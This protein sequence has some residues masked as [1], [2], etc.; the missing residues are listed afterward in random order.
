[1]KIIE[2]HPP[3]VLYIFMDFLCMS[4]CL[5]LTYIIYYNPNLWQL[6]LSKKPFG[7]LLYFPFWKDYVLVF[8]VQILTSLFAFSSWGLY[9]TSREWSYLEEAFVVIKAVLWTILPTAGIIFFVKAKIF[10]RW[11]FIV[12]FFAIPI[13]LMSWR[14]IKRFVVRRMVAKGYNNIHVLIVGTGRA[15]LYLYNEI[16]KYSYLG[17][18]AVGFLSEENLSQNELPKDVLGGYQDFEKIVR[19]YYIDEVYITTLL[20]PEDFKQWFNLAERLGVSLKVVP[21]HLGVLLNDVKIHN[22]GFIPIFE[23][24]SRAIH[25]SELIIKRLFDIFV[26]AILSVILL[27][28]GLLIALLIKLDSPG[29][30]FYIST[31]CGR[32]GKPFQFIKFRTMAQNAD[33]LKERLSSLNEKDGPIFKIKDDPRITRFGKFLRRYSLD[34]IPQF[35][36]V[37][38]G[39]MSLVGPRP[40]LPEEVTRYED[41]QM[42]RLDIRPGITCLWQISGRSDLTF[43]EWMRLDLFYIENWSFW[44]DIKILFQTVWIVI[45]GTGAY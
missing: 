12:S 16:Q 3:K 25:A 2:K 26:S 35:W 14:A 4:V 34:E 11:I 30:I 32:K 37:L 43:N 41:W 6:W 10:S 28:M 22:I 27:P 36:N 13:A 19:R 24:H 15:A 39:Q 5:G 7:S 21:D 42:K 31:R 40:P 17:L 38:T 1:M 20:S 33:E 44:L 8:S 18:D 23:Y 9:R 29:S 45:K